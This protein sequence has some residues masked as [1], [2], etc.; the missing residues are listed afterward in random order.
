MPSKPVG[1]EARHVVCLL[2]EQG[3]KRGGCLSNFRIGLVV[4]PPQE[5]PKVMYV[6]NSLVTQMVSGSPTIAVNN[7]LMSL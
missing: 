2:K 3:K 5:L 1:D 4:P 7:F 6:N